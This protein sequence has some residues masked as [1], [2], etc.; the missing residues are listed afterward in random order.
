MRRTPALTSTF[1]RSRRRQ[2]LTLVVTALSAP[3]L[4]ACGTEKT[5]ADGEQTKPADAVGA[6]PDAPFKAMLDEIAQS[7]PPSAPPEAPPSGP[8]ETLPSGSVETVPDDAI[9]PIA[10]TAGPEVELNARD[11]CASALHEERIA[12]ALWDLAEPTPTKV[13]AILNDLG[14]VD[15]RI[16]DLKQSGAATRFFLDLRDKGGRLCLE[17]SAAGEQT[18]VDKC[19]A[20]ATGPFTAGGRK[21]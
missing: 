9:E 18:V 2:R 8:A 10:P 14:Y 6:R 16:H 11:W 17:G 4:G 1:A 21:Q 7:C 20:P 15:E 12:Q 19:V 5:N 13:R 3:A